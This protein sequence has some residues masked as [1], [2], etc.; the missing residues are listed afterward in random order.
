MVS[1]SIDIAWKRQWLYKVPAYVIKP[2]T[3]LKV[4]RDSRRYLA[5]PMNF[6]RI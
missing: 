6:T 5:Q 1:E 4:A 3:P 2:S